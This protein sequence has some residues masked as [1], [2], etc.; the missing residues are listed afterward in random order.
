MC[1]IAMSPK[2]L[3]HHFTQNIT[4]HDQTTEEEDRKDASLSAEEAGVSVTG[5]W[6]RFRSAEKK[7]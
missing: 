6:V 2:R 4:K 5:I 7:G 1:H 3:C